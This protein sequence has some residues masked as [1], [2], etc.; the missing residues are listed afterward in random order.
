MPITIKA[1]PVDVR[2]FQSLHQMLVESLQQMRNYELTAK[3]ILKSIPRQG[4]TVDTTTNPYADI[5]TWLNAY[6]NYKNIRN[7]IGELTKVVKRLAKS[8]QI[9]IDNNDKEK[10]IG[11]M[12]SWIDEAGKQIESNKT[13]AAILW[14]NC[15]PDN[16]MTQ[17]SY[18]QL[19]KA[20]SNI[21]YYKRLSYNAVVFLE[22]LKGY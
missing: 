17:L 11:I 5:D 16:H 21:A 10:F 9:A 13:S 22:Y 6:R 8:Q 4:S 15:D 18:E 20:N 12:T 1:N 3:V 2:H 14:Q 19:R 7:S